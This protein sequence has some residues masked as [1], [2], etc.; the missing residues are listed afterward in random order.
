[1]IIIYGDIHFY[2]AQ[3]HCNDNLQFQKLFRKAPR[4]APMPA[5]IIRC[6]W[7]APSEKGL[8]AIRML[9]NTVGGVRFSGKKALR[10]CIGQC[11]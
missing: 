3:I 10:S 9:R 4:T 5:H 6:C 8:G 7:N 2:Y 11:Y 1:M